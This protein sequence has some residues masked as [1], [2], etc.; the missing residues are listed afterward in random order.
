MKKKFRAEPPGSA[1][2]VSSLTIPSCRST[3][4]RWL[5][6]SYFSTG[7]LW[8]RC[9]FVS[10]G[11][12]PPHPSAGLALW[13]WRSYPAVGWVL[14]SRSPCPCCAC[15]VLVDVQTQRRAGYC[16][17]G[18]YPSAGLASASASYSTH[19]W[20]SSSLGS[21]PSAGLSSAAASISSGGLVSPS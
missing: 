14:S 15:V 21:Y 4:R 12:Q 20:A 8:A 9:A 11:T 17:R 5:C 2:D 10:F 13:R 6:V 16:P 3:R 18:S 7:G 19:C 1:Q